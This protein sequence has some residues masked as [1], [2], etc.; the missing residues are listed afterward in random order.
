MNNSGEV[1]EVPREASA[2]PVEVPMEEPTAPVRDKTT[3]GS[4]ARKIAANRDNA[5]K[6][7]GPKT[8]RGKASSRRGALKHGFFANQFSDFLLKREDPEEYEELL[9][10]LL[11]DY[12]PIGT[13]ERLVVERIALLWWKLKRCWR[14]ENVAIQTAVHNKGLPQLQKHQ[15]ILAEPQEQVDEVILELEDAKKEVAVSGKM[16]QDITE[17]IFE[18]MP[19]L[20]SIWASLVEKPALDLMT[21]GDDPPDSKLLALVTLNVGITYVKDLVLT[22]SANR[23]E[24]AIAQC[25][26]PNDEDLDRI[27]R[28]ETAIERSLYCS[29]DRLERLQRRRRKGRL[30]GPDESVH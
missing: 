18:I 14:Y 2:E 29:H 30:T 19:D 22:A 7:T 11:D 13:E 1:P 28:C 6:S 20:E 12:Q 24:V 27:H 4:S 15:Q 21:S 23:S 5:A 26:I 3:G 8:P 25:L 9:N 17:R 16:P 10:G